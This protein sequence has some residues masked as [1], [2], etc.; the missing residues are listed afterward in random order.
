MEKVKKIGKSRTSDPTMSD[1]STYENYMALLTALLID[2]NHPHYKSL[3]YDKSLF[4]KTEEKRRI[5]EIDEMRARG[6]RTELEIWY[7]NSVEKNC[8]YNT[9]EY[10]DQ[11]RKR[12]IER[13]KKV[14]KERHDNIEKERKRLFEKYTDDKTIDIKDIDINEAI[15]YKI[16]V[17]DI[18]NDTFKIYDDR[19]IC[20]REINIS[21]RS[22]TTYI[23]NK[24]IFKNRY[25]FMIYNE[26]IS[27]EVLNNI[28]V[29][30]RK[31][32]ATNKTTGEVVIF[33]KLQEASDF[34]NIK[35]P[36]FHRRYA[37]KNIREIGDWKLEDYDYKY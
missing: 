4:D 12:A 3:V 14:S 1:D 16:K 31:I 15:K 32:K 17:V 19:E 22:I 30:T 21:K 36:T 24:S 13:I 7:R 2:E 25:I 18:K 33:N 10:L 23:K 5:K 8:K 35:Y 6:E 27:S 11:K 26:K 34:F 9:E 28:K 29:Q 37:Y 20:A